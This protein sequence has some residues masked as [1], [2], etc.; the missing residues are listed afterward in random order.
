MAADDFS[1]VAP[2]KG[3][4]IVGSSPALRRILDLATH[5]AAKN[6]KVAITGESGVGKD[7]L[8]RF[9][10]AHS[11]RASKPFVALNCAGI[12]ETLLESELF[13]HVRGSFTGAYR[14]KV[15]CFELA[16][17]GTVFLDEIGDMGPRMQGLLLRFLE[18]GEIRRVGSD[19]A[20]RHVDV[21]IISATNRNLYDMVRKGQFREDL[22][23]RV[24]VVQ[25]EVPPLRD[26]KEDIRPL[27]NYV[28]AKAG[29]PLKFSDAAL[30]VLEV[31][32]WPGNV[33]ELQNVVEQ[34]ASMVHARAVEP[35]DLPA[36]V[37]SRPNGPVEVLHDRR[38]SIVTDL[39]EGLTAGQLHF[40]EDVH[41]L[42]TSRDLTRADLRQ[43]IRRGLIASGGSYRG[44]LRLFGM[45]QAD[46]KSLLNF[47]A[48]HDCRVDSR[49]F[50]T[51]IPSIE[52]PLAAT[53]ASR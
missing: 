37:S 40:W 49:R 42:F 32:R 53:R 8:A 39:Y 50:R 6:V 51:E 25:L 16:H 20:T 10:H 41:R 38:R 11:P 33:R 14:D 35:A 24:H 13:G 9:I 5:A 30:R 3:P 34:L 7:V 12:A 36:A 22:Y 43:L 48:A 28:A 47:L 45:A 4:T 31:Y 52:S 1:G 21:R 29:E 2:D 26:R 17:Q 15:G 27:L 18:T 19:T 46:Y 44:L 23:Y